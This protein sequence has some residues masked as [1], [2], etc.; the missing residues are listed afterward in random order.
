MKKRSQNP[1]V[2]VWVQDEGKGERRE[3]REP[4]GGAAGRFDHFVQDPSDLQTPDQSVIE[5][6]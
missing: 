3:K 6:L 4:V 2:P 1:H 5:P